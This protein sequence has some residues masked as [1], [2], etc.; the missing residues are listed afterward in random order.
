MSSS[1]ER[2]TALD[3][4]R[5]IA[6][7]LVVLGHMYVSDA[8]NLDHFGLGWRDPGPV[9]VRLF[10]VLSGFLITGILLR[11]RT[12]QPDNR[13]AI[14]RVFLVRRALRIF[15]LAYLALAVAWC[16]HEP[17]IRA[18]GPWYVFYLSNVGMGL[19]GHYHGVIGHF[20]SLAVEEH[21]YLLWPLVILWI[22]VRHLRKVALGLMIIVC[23]ARAEMLQRD[24]FAA[25]VLT[26]TRLDALVL[27]GWLAIDA[28]DLATLCVASLCL[29]SVAVV[30]PQSWASALSETGMVLASGWVVLCAAQGYADRILT[31]GVLVYVGTISYGIY[32]WHLIVPFIAETAH[33]HLPADR[34]LARLLY[35]SVGTL[36]LASTTWWLFERPAMAL[37]A[38]FEYEART[39]QRPVAAADSDRAIVAN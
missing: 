26:W 16:L 33:I 37:K 27:G 6:V 13:A 5:A 28:P 39:R 34:G 14:W 29:L 12:L 18:Y 8:T 19:F 3:G 21:F 25:Y 4:L 7:A 9:G 11:A 31:R 15:P 22:P 24:Q 17:T 38:R 2:V 10:F 23:A 32:V 20:W 1:P 35:V 30:L 36:A